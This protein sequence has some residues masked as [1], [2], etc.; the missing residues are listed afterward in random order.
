VAKTKSEVR[1]VRTLQFAIPERLGAVTAEAVTRLAGGATLLS[2][3]G[4]WVNERGEVENERINWLVVGVDG[5]ADDIVE[6]VKGILRSSGE[7]AI[8]YV[9]GDKAKLEWL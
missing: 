5:H 3:L 8:F 7:R 9:D 1:A 6:T 4:W 2:G